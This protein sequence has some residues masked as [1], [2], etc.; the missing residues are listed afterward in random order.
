MISMIARITISAVSIFCG[1]RVIAG[2]LRT[3]LVEIEVCRGGYSGSF[4]GL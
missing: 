3:E 1:S 4:V 2:K